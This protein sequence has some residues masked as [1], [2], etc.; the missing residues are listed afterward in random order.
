ME[1]GGGGWWGWGD[2]DDGDDGDYGDSVLVTTCPTPGYSALRTTAREPVDAVASGERNLIQNARAGRWAFEIGKQ[3]K[4]KNVDKMLHIALRLTCKIIRILK[5]LALCTYY[6]P[7]S[8]KM[9]IYYTDLWF[10]IE[11]RK[12]VMQV[13]I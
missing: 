6:L 1:G 2:G 8:V 9:F 3:S 11:S 12:K 13:R 7:I 10:M 4:L 5:Y